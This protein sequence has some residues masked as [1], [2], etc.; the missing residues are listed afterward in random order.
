LPRYIFGK[1]ELRGRLGEIAQFISREA[2]AL[3]HA[4]EFREREGVAAGVWASM[5]M[6][7]PAAV[8]GETRSGLGMNSTVPTRLWGENGAHAFQER[9]TCGGVKMWENIWEKHDVVFRALAAAEVD[10]EKRC[11]RWCRSD[12]CSRRRAFSLATSSTL[13]QSGR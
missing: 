4:F 1:Y 3:E 9:L 2:S 7:K 13:G 12:R 6:A 5:T 11:R 10:I 8:V